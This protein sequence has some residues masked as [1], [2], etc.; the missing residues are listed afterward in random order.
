MKSILDL[1]GSSD[2]AD[3]YSVVMRIL[4]HLQNSASSFDRIQVLAVKVQHPETKKR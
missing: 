2:S 4:L 1:P 3:Q